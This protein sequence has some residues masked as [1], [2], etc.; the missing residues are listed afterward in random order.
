MQEVSEQT[1]SHDHRLVAHISQ[2]IARPGAVY[3]TLGFVGIWLV[4][5]T[6]NAQAF[7]PPPYSLL[8]GF[9]TLCAFLTTIVVLATQRQQARLADQRAHLELQIN[10]VAEHKI[11]KLISLV[12]E[13]RRDTPNVRNR[14]DPIAE[15][16]KQP[17][18]ADD[19]LEV[20][21]VENATQT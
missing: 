17:T 2:L 8:Q 19:I 14:V 4:T 9:L 16:M 11:A 6:I 10:L 21:R 20:M 5:N 18:S 7:D 15:T 13:L 3:L 12:E 1:A